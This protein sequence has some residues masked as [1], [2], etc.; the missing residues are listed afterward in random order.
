M[1]AVAGD[2]Q[3][4]QQFKKLIIPIS[5][6][7]LTADQFRDKRVA[8]IKEALSSSELHQ[9][10]HTYY[11][12]KKAHLD[13]ADNVM[14]FFSLK[15]FVDKA[16][17]LQK[18][19]I[20]YP[21]GY[22]N[23]L[24]S[25]AKSTSFENIESHLFETLNYSTATSQLDFLLEKWFAAWTLYELGKV[26]PDST[27][28]NLLSETASINLPRRGA[29]DKVSEIRLTVELIATANGMKNPFM[30]FLVRNSKFLSMESPIKATLENH[31]INL[32]SPTCQSVHLR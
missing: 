7:E 26:I 6:K 30:N 32:I 19:R 29:E 1:L 15:P 2:P 13:L 4:F 12:S 8:Q 17:A 25:L 14:K 31:K 16:K 5:S 11:T 10:I 18:S 24:G 28:S 20:P 21:R 9:E 23:W 3:R 27:L 22:L